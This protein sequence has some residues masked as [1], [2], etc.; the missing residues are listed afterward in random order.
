MSR[1]VITPW[2]GEPGVICCPMKQNIPDPPPERG[3]EQMACPVCGT[4]CWLT[5]EAKAMVGERP[6]MQ[7]AC[8]SCA[9]SG[10]VKAG[11]KV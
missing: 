6:Y 2:K 3:W 4:L 8:T 11:E 7:L 1:P 9:T 10:R 5:P